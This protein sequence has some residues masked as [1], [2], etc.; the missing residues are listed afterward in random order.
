MN[1]TKRDWEGEIFTV[2]NSVVGTFKK[3]VPFDTDDGWH[4]PQMIVNML[5]ERKCQIFI[6]VKDAKGR[7]VKKGKLIK[8]FGIE[9][10]DE[11]SPSEYVA[12]GRKQAMRSAED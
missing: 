4:V 1:P 6:T 8:E 10:M 11:L 7:K 2:S 3:Y 12:L 9:V 5:Q